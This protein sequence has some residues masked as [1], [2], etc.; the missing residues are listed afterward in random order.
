MYFKKYISNMISLGGICVILYSIFL[1]IQGYFNLSLKLII[2][3][4]IPCLIIFIT[5]T[6]SQ[7]ARQKAEYIS[8]HQEECL[9]KYKVYKQ[10]F[11]LIGILILTT[12]TVIYV[13]IKGV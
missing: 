3:S 11:L 12:S 7:K 4:L 1:S 6:V 8:K 2:L 5:L 9:K 13:V 10:K